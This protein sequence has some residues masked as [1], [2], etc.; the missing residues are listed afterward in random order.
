M[1]VD[2]NDVAIQRDHALR[3]AA[4][5]LK[6]F[7]HT[8]LGPRV[9][10]VAIETD[11]PYTSVSVECDIDEQ[12]GIKDAIV[13]R[14]TLGVP[15]R[16]FPDQWGVPDQRRVIREFAV[17]GLRKMYE[18]KKTESKDDDSQRPRE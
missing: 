1:D 6:Q 11:P 14:G 2:W 18:F 17:D 3:F 13:V 8:D 12:P 9:T 7:T 15:P 4:D 16:E 10:R 5:V